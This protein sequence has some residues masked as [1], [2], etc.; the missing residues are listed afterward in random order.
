M[1]KYNSGVKFDLTEQ[2]QGEVEDELE[3][4]CGNW[5]SIWRIRPPNPVFFLAF[6]TDG[7]LFA[8]AGKTDKLARIWYENQQLLMPSQQTLEMDMSRISYG[9]IY[10]AH[11]RPVTGFSWR[12][13]SKYMPRY[14]NAKQ[15]QGVWM[16]SFVTYM[17]SMIKQLDFNEELKLFGKK[18]HF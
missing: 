5:E 17:E 9:F 18:V 14:K 10:L 11:P 13:T 2:T 8:T 6:S 7:T 12:D 15:V 16:K 3:S 4:R 1:W